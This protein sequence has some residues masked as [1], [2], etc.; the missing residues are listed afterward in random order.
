VSTALRIRTS[1]SGSVPKWRWISL[2]T[3]SELQITAF[4]RGLEKS[5]RSAARR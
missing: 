5:A 2:R 4:R 1:F 3:I